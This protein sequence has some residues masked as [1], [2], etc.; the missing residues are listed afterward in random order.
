MIEAA[1]YWAIVAGVCLLAVI[2]L[3]IISA[4]GKG[5]PK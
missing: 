1:V 3:E 4:G 5:W 2:F